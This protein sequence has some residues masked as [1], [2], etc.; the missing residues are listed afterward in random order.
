MTSEAKILLWPEMK[1]DIGK[2]VKDCTACL[3][4]GKNLKYQL[5]KRYYGKLEKLSEPGQEIQ[6]DLTKLH[7][8]TFTR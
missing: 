8:K 3:I 7:K 4:S 6:I 5:S 2:K 1:Q